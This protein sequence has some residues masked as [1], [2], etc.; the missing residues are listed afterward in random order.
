MKCIEKYSIRIVLTLNEYFTVMS[1]DLITE[2][3]NI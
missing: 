1:K 2:T 3:N